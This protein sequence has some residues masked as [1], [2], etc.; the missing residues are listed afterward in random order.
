[1]SMHPDGPD[2]DGHDFDL[3]P[4]TLQAEPAC[5]A[6]GS[7]VAK[8]DAR[9]RLSALDALA[10]H[11][12]KQECYGK[13][14]ALLERKW[15]ERFDALGGLRRSNR[16]DAR[17]H[18][19]LASLPLAPEWYAMLALVAVLA[20]L[21]AFWEPLAWIVWPLFALGIATPVAQ[22]IAAARHA[23]C[24]AGDGAAQRSTSRT[25][26]MHLIR[27]AARLTG[28]LR[29]GLTPWRTRGNRRESG[30]LPEEQEL[31][32]TTSRP[33][34]AWM[35]CIERTLR[36]RGTIVRR[37]D[38]DAR[39]LEVIV[40]QMGRVR[41]RVEVAAHGADGQLVRTRSRFCVPLPVWSIAIGSALLA[42]C[43]I[44][45]DAWIAATGLLLLMLLF[46]GR[47]LRD[48]VAAA[49]AWHDAVERL[50]DEA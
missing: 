21:A 50:R 33:V 22:A 26:L 7:S 17:R 15:P 3:A 47:A 24:P 10:L 32:S 41:G 1:M 12:R 13:A 48:V 25:V 4:R 8:V 49:G 34:D 39:A 23:R 35:A 20:L 19:T 2:V 28:R 9:R 30:A 16:L 31:S 5:E 37:A 27:P 46:A 6:R 43:A 29:H 18:G 11:W 38:D 42:M 14:E 45:D 44:A 40:G 36:E